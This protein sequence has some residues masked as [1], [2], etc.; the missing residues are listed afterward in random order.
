[1]TFLTKNGEK[2]SS[3][4]FGAGGEFLSGDSNFKD[5]LTCAL[6]HGLNFIDTA[7]VYR[8]GKSEKLIGE[9]LGGVERQSIFIA[10]KI[11]PEHISPNKFLQALENSLIR[12]NTDYIDLYQIH[13]PVLPKQL[14]SCLNLIIKAQSNGLIRH[15]GFSN[16]TSN[17]LDKII[18]NIPNFSSVQFEYSLRD[19]Y[20]EYDL[21]PYVNK[22]NLTPIVY[23]FFK[24]LTT[25]D[26]HCIE[27]ISSKYGISPRAFI[28]N[29][30]FKKNL[31]VLI[32]T[33]N[34]KH[35]LENICFSK[36]N[37]GDEEC[38]QL[39]A[40]IPYEMN[41][42]RPSLMKV[43]EAGSAKVYTTLIEAQNNLWGAHPSPRD[44]AVELT[45]ISIQKPIKAKLVDGQ[46]FVVQGSMRYWGW[47]IAFGDKPM[48]V[49]IV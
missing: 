29:W 22:K 30:A 5:L 37:V 33:E 31:K 8:D 26:Y 39:E 23:G 10:T 42:I 13:W 27:N 45:E 46:L 34:K 25:S 14:D 12:L 43:Y 4:G 17:Y 2:L 3:V 1:M 40:V 41:Y 35:L 48:P 7:E 47:V 16:C 19:R 36:L 9:V 15:I 38:R 18:D 6:E 24:N 32:T 44:M 49:V 28:L 11:S 21:L 20:A